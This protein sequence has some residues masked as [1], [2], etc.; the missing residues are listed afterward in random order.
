MTYGTLGL[1]KIVLIILTAIVIIFASVV[2]WM[3]FQVS[4]TVVNPL[5]KLMLELPLEKYSIQRLSERTFEGSP[6]ILDAPVAT[7]SS[8]TSYT[9]HY[10]SDGK[11]VTGLAHFPTGSFET[12]DTYPVIVQFRGFVD[13]KI[14]RPG[15]GTERS[16]QVF[17]KHGYIS[18]APDFL[19]YAGSDKE[20]QDIF[21]SRFET[22]TSALTLLSSLSSLP[23]VDTS[24]V[25]IWGHSN[26]GQIALT[27]LEVVGQHASLSGELRTYPTALWAPVS[28]PFPY[29]ILYY[30]DEAEDHGKFLR[31]ELAA[32]ESKYDAE[33]YSLTNYLDWITSPIQLHQGTGDDAVPVAWS[34]LLHTA[35]EDKKKDITYYVYP[36][37]DHN[38]LGAWDQVITRDI[39]FF[40]KAFAK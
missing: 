35:L 8:Y 32:F 12:K 30:T 3:R 1:M 16:A 13:Q 26:G 9:F 11:K 17:A 40:D 5:G 34:D 38:M 4:Q 20:A 28:K 14:Y 27:V 19:G 31:K 10:M 36:G 2:L 37:A 25:G 18:L 23:M 22:Y 24:K 33:A 39:E 6:I 7:E 21:E 15:I 29:S